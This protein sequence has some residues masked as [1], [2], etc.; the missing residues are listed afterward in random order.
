M[1]PWASGLA[2]LNFDAQ[3]APL[4]LRDMRN[5]IM[6]PQA[7][8]ACFPPGHAVVAPC[9]SSSALA[10]CQPPLDE[11]CKTG[12]GVLVLFCSGHECFTSAIVELWRAP[13]ASFETDQ[14]RVPCISKGGHAILRERM[15]VQPTNPFLRRKPA[16]CR[17]RS[18]TIS[19]NRADASCAR[20]H[21]LC[22][23][24]EHHASTC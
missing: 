10:A 7:C 20:A 9:I 2:S 17:L 23:S 21:G 13:W 24:L 11:I 4:L 5:H 8:R 14:H 19:G 18:A 16:N 3:S 22:R 12:T 6:R 1:P 15:R